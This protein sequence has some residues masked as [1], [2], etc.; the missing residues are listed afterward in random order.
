MRYSGPNG[1][2]LIITES[3]LQTFEQHRQ[4]SPD[5]DEAGGQLFAKFE[6]NNV[7]ICE[8]THPKESDKRGRFF[9]RP[10][11]QKERKEIKE[12]YIDGLHYVGDWHTHPEPTP[13]P[14]R[15]DRMS[16]M[17]CFQQSLHQLNYFFMI[18][19]GNKPFP[20]GLHV[21]ANNGTSHQVLK[22]Y[23]SNSS[24]N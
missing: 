18:I 7:I 21:S 6:E 2:T 15:E 10:D 16:V 13:T 24:D 5:K 17:E 22:I 12:K 19:V 1:I 11:R 4:N 14:S 9:F 23:S 3:V 20:I 8:A